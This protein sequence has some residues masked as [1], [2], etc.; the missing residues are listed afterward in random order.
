LLLGLAPYQQTSDDLARWE[1]ALGVLTTADQDLE[2]H[3][4]HAG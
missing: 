3:W 2:L 4:H 1:A